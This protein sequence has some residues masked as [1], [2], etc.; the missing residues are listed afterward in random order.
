MKS[1]DDGAPSGNLDAMVADRAALPKNSDMLKEMGTTLFDTIVKEAIAASTASGDATKPF[2]LTELAT[3][4]AEKA[5]ENAIP[6]RSGQ[7][8]TKFQFPS[9]TVETLNPTRQLANVATPMRYALGD[10]SNG[11]PSKYGVSNLLSM[12]HQARISED[13][14]TTVHDFNQA[15]ENPKRYLSAYHPAKGVT[16]KLVPSHKSALTEHPNNKRPRAEQPVEADNISQEK[17]I[18]ITPPRDNKVEEK[19]A[20]TAQVFTNPIQPIVKEEVTDIQPK[21]NNEIPQ[22]LAESTL[23]NCIRGESTPNTYEVSLSIHP[24]IKGDKCPVCGSSDHQINDCFWAKKL[25]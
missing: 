8:D 14:V 4:V 3:N 17:R 24:S 16:F 2:I 10:I 13:K 22:P 7:L 23:T 6:G 20:A 15:L 1:L 11:T 5:V 19:P 12:R 25:R 18:T 9:K 21:I